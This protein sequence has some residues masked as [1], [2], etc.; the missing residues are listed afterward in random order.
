MG[1]D[2]EW[3]CSAGKCFPVSGGGAG[4][5]EDPG[6]GGWRQRGL[7]MEGDQAQEPSLQNIPGSEHLS[8]W[9][10]ED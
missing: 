10:T 3:N 9:D 4:G 8:L 1:G 7:R 5:E 2:K 6:W